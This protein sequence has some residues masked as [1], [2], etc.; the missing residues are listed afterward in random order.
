MSQYT[1]TTLRIDQLFRGSFE[2]FN[3][4]DGDVRSLGYAIVQPN[5]FS[6]TDL[7][8]YKTRS[9]Q[10]YNHQLEVLL[11]P[12]FN[13]V[14]LDFLLTKIEE[15]FPNIRKIIMRETR[16]GE[17]RR[18]RETYARQ[19]IT[20]TVVESP[21]GMLCLKFRGRVPDIYSIMHT[22]YIY[23]LAYSLTTYYFEN[24]PPVKPKK[25][26]MTREEYNMCIKRHKACKKDESIFCTLSLEHIKRGQT[27]A[28]TCCGHQF[29][30][31][32]LRRWLTKE[33]TEPTCPLCRQNLLTTVSV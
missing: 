7:A 3:A 31:S 2:N 23:D 29:K 33:C 11:G 10:K 21:N 19:N 28:T 14:T 30:S 16:I 8:M 25:V 24:L 4:D 1:M 27:V 5:N 9:A 20:G 18:I 6:Y 26:T 32:E 12:D 13:D 17:N 15:S 22:D